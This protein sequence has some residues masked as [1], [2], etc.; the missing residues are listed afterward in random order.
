MLVFYQA[1]NEGMETHRLEFISTVK[2]KGI[3]AFESENK[4]FF[5][6]NYFVIL[7]RM[8]RCPVKHHETTKP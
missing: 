3:Y 8:T 6:T 5:T 4:G 2:R 1:I 7:F